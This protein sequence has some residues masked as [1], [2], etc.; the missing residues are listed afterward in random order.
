MH[1]N[2][3]SMT[4]MTDSPLIGVTRAYARAPNGDNQQSVIPVISTV[5]ALLA[6]DLGA[7]TGW[8]LRTSGEFI[9]NGG[10]VR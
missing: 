1:G 10:G 3:T 2:S 8:A 7:T 5:G 6:L 4:D 9:E